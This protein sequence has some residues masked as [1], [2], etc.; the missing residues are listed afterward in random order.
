M[1]S[2]S[3]VEIKWVLRSGRREEIRENQWAES[4]VKRAPLPGMP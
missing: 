2:G 3:V 1:E 4:W